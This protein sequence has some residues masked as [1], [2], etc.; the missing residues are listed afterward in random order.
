VV[1]LDQSTDVVFANS[2]IAFDGRVLELFGHAAR[3]GNRIHVVQITDIVEEADKI[4][5]TI[6]GSIDYSIDLTGGDE[7]VRGEIASLIAAVRRAAPR[8]HAG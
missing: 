8:I 5:I 3:T 7:I 4:V 2:V 1:S 6:R